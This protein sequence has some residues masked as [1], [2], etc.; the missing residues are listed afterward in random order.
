[1]ILFSSRI[2]PEK[3]A[4]TLLRA[5]KLLHDEGRDVLI[6]NRSGGYR[7]FLMLAAR[8][9]A[10]GLVDARDAIDPVTALP[11]LYQASN[12]CVQASREEGLGFSP[13]EALAC[14]TPVV[15]ASVGG[16]RETIISG[17]TGWSYPR[18]NVQSLAA[19]LR[20]V[21]SD[22]AEAERRTARGRAMVLARYE[23]EKAFSAFK[24]VAETMLELAK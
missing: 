21:F 6:V 9:G 20:E 16:L 2:A 15:A 13:L 17:D 22:R 1:M 23:R 4:E 5:V 3:D 14:G 19:A 18:G 24:A 12:V 8:L 11:I 7:D 10:A